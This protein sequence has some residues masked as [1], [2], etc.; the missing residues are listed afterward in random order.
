[1]RFRNS[2]RFGNS[3]ASILA[4]IR[5][6]RDGRAEC[7]RQPG[8]EL[9]RRQTSLPLGTV[10]RIVPPNSPPRAGTDDPTDIAQHTHT[11]DTPD[12]PGPP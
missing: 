1:M 8:E 2:H 5:N 6:L 4:P 11:Y 7:P 3:S 12:T 9:D 10:A